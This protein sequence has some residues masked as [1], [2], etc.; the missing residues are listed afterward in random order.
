VIQHL[1][2]GQRARNIKYMVNQTTYTIAN[3][4]LSFLSL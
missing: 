2:Y 4:P 1:L 3:H